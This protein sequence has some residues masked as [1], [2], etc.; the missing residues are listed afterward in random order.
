MPTARCPRCNRAIGEVEQLAMQGQLEPGF[1][2]RLAKT[3]IFLKQN[4]AGIEPSDRPPRLDWQ[5]EQVLEERDLSKADQFQQAVT[6]LVGL[7]KLLSQL[8]APYLQRVAERLS[9]GQGRLALQ[10]EDICASG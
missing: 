4:G 10:L 3:L 2:C 1:T 6:A 5:I 7:L 9:G 8:S